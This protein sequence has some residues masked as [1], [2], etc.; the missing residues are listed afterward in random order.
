MSLA[1]LHP[2]CPPFRYITVAG[3][4]VHGDASAPRETA[5]RIAF[6][7]YEMVCG[8]GAVSGDGVVPV[9]AAHLPDTAAT[10]LD[11]P[12]ALHSIN[13]PGTVLP[14][15][16]WYGAEPFVDAWLGEVLRQLRG[17]RKPADASSKGGGASITELETA[18][19]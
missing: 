17:E 3:A 16:Q 18:V 4:G 6:N 8:Q 1:G 12:T 9:C 10:R 13:I 19:E 7:S 15:D 2:D 5:E 11:L 14:T